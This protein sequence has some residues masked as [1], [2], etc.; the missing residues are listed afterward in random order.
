M[1]QN[2]TYKKVG[3]YIIETSHPLGSGQYGVV[4]CG[5]LDEVNGDANNTI[6]AIKETPIPYGNNM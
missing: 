6:F 3:E 5:S 4:Y 1:S 2:K